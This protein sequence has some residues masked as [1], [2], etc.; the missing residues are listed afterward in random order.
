MCNSFRLR[1]DF[2]TC[3]TTKVFAYLHMLPRVQSPYA[4]HSGASRFVHMQF[5][6][7]YLFCMCN[8][9]R[10]CAL[11]AYVIKS[12]SNICSSNSD[13]AHYYFE[14]WWNT[15]QFIGAVW[16][17]VWHMQFNNFHHI[18]SYCIF[19]YAKNL[20]VLHM[21]QEYTGYLGFMHVQNLQ[22]LQILHMQPRVHGIFRY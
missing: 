11:F 17:W 10:R 20:Y 9:K 3:Y 6:K 13:F 5:L 7:N 22:K 16:L 2:C 15:I 8:S 19:T 21:Y 14:I 4:I 1:L 18:S 12:T